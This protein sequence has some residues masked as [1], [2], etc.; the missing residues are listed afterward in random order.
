MVSFLKSAFLLSSSGN[1]S[2][3]RAEEYCWAITHATVRSCWSRTNSSVLGSEFQ[4]DSL[5]CTYIFLSYA[6]WNPFL[7]VHTCKLFGLKCPYLQTFRSEV[8]TLANSS[9]WSVYACRP[10]GLMCPHLQT[11]RTEVSTLASLSVWSVH[12]CKSFDLKCS[13][14]QNLRSDVSTPANRW[15]WSVHTCK[16][17]CLKCPHLQTI[18]SKASTLANLLS[19]L[20]TLANG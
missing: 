9:V 15:V 6:H 12:T 19:K 3:M 1:G 14:L 2:K 7:S 10:F 11:D 16:P 18:R 17:F 13:H 20:S 4:L 8:P 5:L